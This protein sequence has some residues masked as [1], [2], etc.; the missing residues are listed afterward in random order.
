MKQLIPNQFLFRF[1]FACRYA[2]QLPNK[3]G[4]P[5]KLDDAYRFPFTGGMDG[6]PEFAK[7][8]MGWNENG[9]GIAYS[10][11]TKDEPIYGEPGRPKGCDGLSLWLDTRDTRTIHRSSKFCQRFTFTAHDGSPA[12]LPAAYRLNIH[13]AL[14]E[15]PSVDMSLIQLA[16]FAVYDGQLQAQDD[17]SKIRGYR[18]E[19]FLP[20]AVL[21]GF[22][23]ETNSRL[24]IFFRIR[25]REL[26]D[27]L[28]G[29]G[30]ELPYWEDPS[31]WSTFE[32]LRP[33]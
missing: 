13:R 31:L 18:M 28:S 23:P 22:D 10:I 26:G 27:Q 7:V 17:P 24:G 3:G 30:A 32:L 12:G 15:P 5:V 4:R 20:A 29:A 11:D 2:K 1:A 19:I 8:W 14:E 9:L 21:H 6:R 33:E 25:D 16:R